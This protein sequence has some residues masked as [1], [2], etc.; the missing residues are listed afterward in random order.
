MEINGGLDP[1]PKLAGVFE[2]ADTPRG[3]S[4]VRQRTLVGDSLNDEQCSND[5]PD[6]LSH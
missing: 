1:N 5:L 4:V 3:D 2:L 6:W